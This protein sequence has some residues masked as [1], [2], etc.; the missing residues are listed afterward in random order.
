MPILTHFVPDVLRQ[1]VLKDCIDDYG[2]AED[3]NAEWPNNILSRRAIVYGNGTIARVGEPVV[4]NADSDELDLCIRLANEAA[5]IMEGEAVGMG[6][7]SNAGF[8]AFWICANGDEVPR[9]IDEHLIRARFG[10]TI[11]PQATIK[12]EPISV[13]ADLLKRVRQELEE[14]EEDDPTSAPEYRQSI[15]KWQMLIKWF[16]KQA[17]FRESAWV[18]IGDEDELWKLPKDQYPPGTEMTPSVLPRLLLGLTY[19]GSLCGLFGFVV[20]T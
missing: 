3:E 10:H 19:A 14:A 11:F 7:E 13:T 8:S 2:V 6:S 15:E 17:E 4:F 18:A 5:T 12:I 20:Y 9:H 16:G 1:A